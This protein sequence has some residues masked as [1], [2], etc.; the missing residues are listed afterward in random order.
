[1][2]GT[3]PQ[4]EAAIGDALSQCAKDVKPLGRGRW[5]IGLANGKSFAAL[6]RL[7]DSWL[8]LE[9]KPALPRPTDLVWELL[10]LNGTISGGSKL[11]LPPDGAVLHL[12]AEVPAREDADVTRRLADACRSLEVAFGCVENGKLRQPAHGAVAAAK[13][14]GEKADAAGLP[15][16][17]SEAGWASVVRDGKDVAVQLD[18]PGAYYLAAV[19]TRAGGNVRIVAE[20][21]AA[22]TFPPTVRRALGRLLLVGS[23]LVRQVRAA[24]STTAA[25]DTVRFEVGFGSLP[26]GAEL[27]IALEAL[28]VACHSFGREAKA[29]AQETVASA[30]LENY[31]EPGGCHADR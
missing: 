26:S 18:V 22:E 30:Y 8:V 20:V 15:Q 25:G 23:G 4:R 7:E 3:V 21:A 9:A 5:R 19:D 10:A 11:T 24:A 1:M 28:S 6:A 31:K 14:S 16:L 12:Q 13:E 2:T 17:V 29:L 27:S